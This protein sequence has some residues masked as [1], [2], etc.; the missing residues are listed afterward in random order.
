M[1]EILTDQGSALP[2]PCCSTGSR[3]TCARRTSAPPAALAGWQRRQLG[4]SS[5]V[6]SWILSRP[7]S[8]WCLSVSNSLLRVGK[9]WLPQCLS[10]LSYF[11][12]PYNGLSAPTL[13][14]M[15]VFFIY[16]FICG[17]FSWVHMKR[18]SFPLSLSQVPGC[19]RFAFS[20]ISWTAVMPALR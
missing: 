5:K 19:C 3:S 2:S 14:K 17:A 13:S 4:I 12:L 6:V 8:S 7:F 20:I 11:A 10:Q 15:K 18:F 1:V 16:A 9:S